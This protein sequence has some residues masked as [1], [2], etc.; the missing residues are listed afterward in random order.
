VL[1][2]NNWHKF[3]GVA[4]IDD[5]LVLS[6]GTADD[7]DRWGR[8]KPAEVTRIGAESMYNLHMTRGCGR[9]HP[10]RGSR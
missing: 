7:V 5:L 4:T 3:L 2:L 9:G 8:S 1:V 6:I 10:V